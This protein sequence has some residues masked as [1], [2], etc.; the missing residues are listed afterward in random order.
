MTQSP[1]EPEG[2][3]PRL[4]RSEVEA[5]RKVCDHFFDQMGEPE[6]HPKTLI[7]ELD[8]NEQ[9]TKTIKQ[10]H[11]V[12]WPSPYLQ[13]EDEGVQPDGD[14]PGLAGSPDPDSIR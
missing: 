4:S 7:I 5:F 13:A 8:Q 11:F 6:D 9:P 10:V 1:T 3:A 2:N 12:I 14:Q